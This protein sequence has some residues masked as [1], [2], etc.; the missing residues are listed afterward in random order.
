MKHLIPFA[1]PRQ[2][3]VIEA[4]I[5]YGSHQKAARELGINRSNVS[6]AV[7]A[8]RTKA[9]KSGIAPEADMV[10]QAAEGF[11]VQGT[12]TLYKDGEAVIQWHMVGLNRQMGK[13]SML[14]F[15]RI[16]E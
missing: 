7:Q 16:T 10:H 6:R 15:L 13:M 4:V 12:S 14:C 8:V 5:R 3:E 9:A 1:T 11:T 2:A